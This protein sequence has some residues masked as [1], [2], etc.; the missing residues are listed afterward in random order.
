MCPITLL[1]AVLAVTPF[2]SVAAQD[3]P[4]VRPG[5]RVRVTAPELNLNKYDGTLRVM[6]DDTL[7]VDTLRIALLSVRRLEVRRAPKAR[8]LTVSMYGGVG[9]VLGAATGAL[10]VP[11]TTSSCVT[12]EQ[13]PV[14][15]QD[16]LG[17]LAQGPYAKRAIQV[18]LV[19]MVIGI[20]VGLE[21]SRERWH[22]VPL[23]QL[24]VTFVPEGGGR[25]AL[26]A[27]VSF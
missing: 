5:S 15:Q 24:R 10:T 2:T 3:S 25:F 23:D 8:G 1:L 16:C 26:T 20:V 9:L 18:G 4:P 17:G 13:S 14:T 6:P 7:I 11:L 12:L 21:V 22:E 27:S 19:G